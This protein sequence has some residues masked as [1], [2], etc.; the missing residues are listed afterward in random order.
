MPTHRQDTARGRVLSQ[1][2]WMR[3][4]MNVDLDRALDDC[5]GAVSED[6]GNASYHGSLGWVWMRRGQTDKSVSEFNEAIALDPNALWS[7]YGRGLA[8]VA[9]GDPSGAEGDLAASRKFDPHIDERAR[10]MG[11]PTDERVKPVQADAAPASA[12]ASR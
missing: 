9:Q 12:S 2:C 1:R 7:L 11:L 4:R 6:R 3:M 8:K 10:R 5:R